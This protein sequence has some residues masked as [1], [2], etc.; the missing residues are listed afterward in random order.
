MRLIDRYN[1]LVREAFETHSNNEGYGIVYFT[2]FNYMFYQ[3]AFLEAKKNRVKTKFHVT[4]IEYLPSDIPYFSWPPTKFIKARTT[5]KT[6]SYG[7]KTGLFK[8]TFKEKG[9]EY[10][11]IQCCYL[12]GYKND[13]ICLVCCTDDIYR[14]LL[15]INKKAQ[16][17]AAKPPMGV[18][19]AW[20]DNM[21]NL[22]YKK[23]DKGLSNKMT[24]HKVKQ[25]INDDISH[26][27]KNLESSIKNGE[28]GTR[29]VLLAGPQGTGKSSIIQE[30]IQNERFL[31]THS[32]I[33]AT[34]IEAMSKHCSNL[35][36]YSLPS[37]VILED[38][39]TQF[40][41]R[42]EGTAVLNFLSGPTEPKNA[43]GTYM[44]FT[45][46][47]PDQL[48]D[49]IKHRPER[50]DEIFIVDAL[51]E[52]DALEVTKMYFGQFLPKKFDWESLRGLFKNYTGAEIMKVAQD[53]KKEAD[54]RL[55]DFSKVTKK[56]IE[57]VITE[58]MNKYKKLEQVNT[59]KTNL[60][61]K[62]G[63]LEGNL[64][65]SFIQTEAVPPEW[66]VWEH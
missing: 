63:A 14:K 26:F 52:A 10:I 53:V 24:Y 55:H 42:Q 33:I 3:D 49:R 21:G 18:N 30:I 66:G 15:D 29:K 32:I 7:N 40:G 58:T 17:K 11:A 9:K 25:K 31:K 41:Q 60:S 48:S 4:N 19:V 13:V 46:N 20:V 43:G 22:K 36:R 23:Y 65:F 54:Y 56:F 12:S 28:K 16:K 35:T 44:F 5:N 6:T 62:S 39:E 61:K 2:E 51:D 1:K 47:H 38:C 57:K 34:T 37:I 59:N 8:I 64:G 27:Y 45:T 50:I